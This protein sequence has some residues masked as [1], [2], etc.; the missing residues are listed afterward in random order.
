MRRSLRLSTTNLLHP[1]SRMRSSIAASTD[2][3]RHA[4]HGPFYQEGPQLENFYVGSAM[5]RAFLK[6]HLPEDVF[7][8]VDQ[9]LVKFG[10]R[11]STDIYTWGRECEWHQPSMRHYDS[12]GKRVDQLITCP[13][14]QQ[15]K[16]T[17]AEEGLISL[18]YERPYG[19]HSRLVQMAKTFLFHPN[20]GLVTCPLAMTDG[21]AKTIEGL[22]DAASPTLKEAYRRLTSPNPDEAW[23]SGQWMTERRGGSDVASGTETLAKSDGNGNY[24]LYGFKWFS[25]A[26][27]ADMSL[28]LARVVD[29]KG[30]VIDGTRGLSMFYL[31][32]RREDG[33]LNGIQ[34]VQLKNK[35]GTKQLPTAELL[36][37]GTS[38]EIVS[39]EGRGVAFISRVLN[40]TRL[41]SAMGSTSGTRRLLQLSRDYSLR[42]EAFG[43]KIVNYPLHVFTLFNIDV[44]CRGGEL[45]SLHM[46]QL[47]GRED[48]GIATPEEQLLLRLLTPV[49]KAFICKNNIITT[50]ELLESF[51]GLGYIEDTPL[52]GAFRD[53]QVNSI[54]EGTTNVLSL[55]V[56]RVIYKTQGEAARILLKSLQQTLSGDFSE[57]LSQCCEEIFAAAEKFEREFTRLIE[58]PSEMETEARNI[59]FAIGKIFIA[60]LMVD[61]ARWSGSVVDAAVAK[62][63]IANHIG[64]RSGVMAARSG[65]VTSDLARAAVMEGYDATAL[66]GPMF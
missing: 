7:T 8:E 20:S 10:R 3:F 12:Y 42:R 4:K 55:D 27:D 51:G 16:R 31:P 23:T 62:A 57:Q 18:A 64:A 44:T 48:M 66:C 47:L 46:A 43:Q 63:W 2:A 60:T 37:D 6:R 28:T 50:S 33:S 26:I 15:L 52:P 29:A 35:M 34:V 30:Q 56:L 49:L 45:F 9:S 32:I 53:T 38:A 24:K 11:C 61:H 65:T 54:W 58:A 41:H 1:I 19:V 25:S 59:T 40:I 21:A 39:E 13:G 36:L 17:A 22:G 5:L 14:W